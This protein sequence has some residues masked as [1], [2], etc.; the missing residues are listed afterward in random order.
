LVK[1]L[2]E[3]RL[4]IIR[5]RK[6]RH[7]ETGEVH[8]IK[9]IDK[10]TVKRESMIE[11]LKREVSILMLVDHPHIV[12]LKEVMTSNSKIYLVLEFVPG[13]ELFDLI[14]KNGKLEEPLCRKYFVQLIRALGHCKGHTI[15]HRDIKPE[16]L[17]IDANGDLKVS[18]FGLSSLFKDPINL[19]LIMQTPCG[20]VNYLAP[21]VIQN[22]GYDGHIADIWS[23]GILLY[24]CASGKLP[25]ADDNI[26][27]LL[28]KI[29]EAKPTYPKHFS[30][31]LK[32]LLSRLLEPNFKKR[33]TLEQIATHPWIKEHLTASEMTVL[34]A[35]VNADKERLDEPQS[36]V[37]INMLSKNSLDTDPIQTISLDPTELATILAG[38]LIHRII[39][40]ADQ[41]TLFQE[42]TTQTSLSSLDKMIM[43]NLPTLTA[44]R[45]TLKQYHSP[46]LFYI[47]QSESMSVRVDVFRLHSYPQYLF[48]S[49]KQETGPR[50]RYTAFLSRVNALFEPI[51]LRRPSSV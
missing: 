15:A 10:E 40:P 48:V 26:S 32:Q 38:K 4:V 29:I 51:L 1:A 22:P 50:A 45:A 37:A 30:A 3:C 8:A 39:Q 35:D 19:N 21:E 23:A 41:A 17:L 43:D 31:S 13:G 14:K 6:G 36:P 47:V 49:I 11:S 46:H 2:S 44:P 42:F 20:T 16:N 28:E 24:V 9:I 34:M 33:A 7:I 18:D 12:K 27:D 5:V 25:F